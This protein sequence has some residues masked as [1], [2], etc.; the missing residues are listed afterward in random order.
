MNRSQSASFHGRDHG[1]HAAS[2]A[3]LRNEIALTRIAIIV[4]LVAALASAAVILRAAVTPV[5]ARDGVHTVAQ[6][7]FL[8][9]VITMIY[10]SCVYQ[11]TRLAYLGRLLVHRRASDEE[12][13]RVYR[14]D[15]PPTVSVLVPSYK[16]E[17][18]VVRKTLLSASLQE[19][20]NRR[21][22]LLIDDPPHSTSVGDIAGLSATRRLPEEIQLVLHEPRQRCDKAFRDFLERQ[23]SGRLEPTEELRRLEGL[24]RHIG[25]W[26]DFQAAAHPIADHVDS[27]FVELTYRGPARRCLEQSREFAARRTAG[28][29]PTSD[30]LAVAYRRL[31]T[32]FQVEITTFERKRYANLSHESNKAMNLNSYIG[33]MGRSFRKAIASDGRWVLE[34]TEGDRADLRVPNTDYVL[35]LDADSILDSEY[36]LRLVHLME[37]PGNEHVA[38]AQTPYSS[39]PHAPGILERV[40]GATTDIQYIIHQ[41]FTHYG[42]T[43]WVGANAI[44]RKCALDDI[45]VS[46]VERDYPV[47]KFIQDRTVI[48]DTE[49][50]VD[51]VARG[52][53]LYNYPER[54]AF[55]ATP[56]DFGSLLIQRRRWAN[57]GLLILPKLLSYLVRH[58]TRGRRV[59]E[60]LVRCHYLTS[61]TTANVGLLVILALPLGD[62][63]ETL[64]L[65]LA[66]LPYYLLYARDLC[67]IG[68]PAT[69]VLRVY[70][71]NLLL[72]PVNLAG[73]CKSL[74]QACTRQKTVFGRTPKIKGKTVAPRWYLLAEYSLLAQWLFAATVEFLCGR[75][76]RAALALVNA[77]FLTYAIAT[78]IGAPR[79]SWHRLVQLPS[80]GVRRASSPVGI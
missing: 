58:V 5:D 41:G 22:V 48:E 56:P 29:V 16:E 71:L 35:M 6:L 70:A 45:A 50:S 42:A 60:G 69:D 55:S 37:R 43:F 2:A 65:P 1:N 30:Q 34:A 79:V 77:A 17:P 11:F 25:E 76:L 14:S 10:G 18:D 53:Q 4:T 67:R 57:G 47:R 9:L 20:P 72:I 24:Y 64:W 73:V 8:L 23:A 32:R 27:L 44:V 40:A 80:F 3:D 63:V 36:T 7:F 75:H 13:H 19:Y 26:F 66:A 52:W 21:V 49:S 62:R 51:L 38:V 39:F 59:A 78:F 61:I 15:R 68:Y 28:A 54:L 74:H 12:L 33:L 31:A 46:A